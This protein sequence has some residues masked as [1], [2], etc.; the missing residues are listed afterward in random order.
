ME[1][2]ERTLAQMTKEVEDLHQEGMKTMASDIAEL[3]SGEGKRLRDQSR[4][5][6]VKGAGMGGVALAIGSAVIP[7]SSLWNSAFAAGTPDAEDVAIAKFA[8]SVELAAVAAYTVAA[9]TGKVTGQGLATAKSFLTQHQAHANAFSGFA[10]DTKTAVANPKLVAAIGPE[11]KAA[12]TETDIVK[13]AYGLENAAAA[14]YLYAIGALKDKA[15]L[16]LTA[17][18]LPVESQHATVWGTVL[19]LS[20]TDIIP[21]FLKTT[22][23]VNPTMYPI[24][25]G[26]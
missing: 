6:F 14:T 23:Y 9:G 25:A 11:I 5:S 24:K 4:R 3:H 8:A 7:M 1:I 17:T 20:L 12:A 22:G 2:S 18:I 10:G 16:A 13:I 26:S 15:A 21:S 19:G